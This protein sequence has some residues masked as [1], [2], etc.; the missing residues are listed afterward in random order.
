MATIVRAP[1]GCEH[2]ALSDGYRRIRIDVAHG[3]LLAGAVHL[4]YLLNG[5]AGVDAKLLTLRRLMALARLGRLARGL[6]PI[7][8]LAPRWVA[9]LRTH[10]ALSAGAS[11]RDVARVLFGIGAG[12]SDWRHGS[13]F[14][15]L[16]VQRLARIG[17]RMVQGG[18][19]T[20]LG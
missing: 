9:A 7:E 11:Q 6:Y 1:D 15:R 2:V 12:G 18:Y 5:L 17:R 20:L 13:D 8:R 10:D 4:D 19:R 14:F 3:T 16:R